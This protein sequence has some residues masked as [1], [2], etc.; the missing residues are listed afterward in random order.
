M[1]GPMCYGQLGTELETSLR[2]GKLGNVVACERDT[3]LTLV[4]RCSDVILY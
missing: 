3:S 2:T 1:I 4:D